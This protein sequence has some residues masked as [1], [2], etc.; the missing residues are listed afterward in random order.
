MTKATKRTVMRVLRTPSA[1]ALICTGA[2]CATAVLLFAPE[3][4]RQWILAPGGGIAAL[5]ALF[6]RLRPVD[7]D[8]RP[9]L[10]PPGD[11][12]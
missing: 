9:T 7:D 1:V 5:L 3:E 10:P 6:V 12:S 4:T 8:G 11:E 2:L